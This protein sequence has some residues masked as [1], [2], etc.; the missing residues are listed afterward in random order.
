M[1]QLGRRLRHD[2]DDVRSERR[3]PRQDA[4]RGAL[5]MVARRWIGRA[6]GAALLALVVAACGGSGSPA[7]GTAAKTGG[8]VGVVATPAGTPGA[9]GTAVAENPAVAAAVADLAK[10]KGVEPSRIGVASVE[11]VEWPDSSLGCPQ[12]GRAYAQVITPGWRIRLTLD[13]QTYEYHANQDGTTV[14]LC[15]P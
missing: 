1:E 9:G 13:G 10:Q 8:T 14:V 12:P 5:V 7:A 15:Q 4:M 11:A 6:A 3:G 2:S